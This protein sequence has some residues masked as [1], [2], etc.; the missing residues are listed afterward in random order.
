MQLNVK[1]NQ[2]IKLC[3]KAC[4]SFFLSFPGN[5]WWIRSWSSVI[6][7]SS[8]CLFLGLFVISWSLVRQ[9]EFYVFLGNLT[10]KFKFAHAWSGIKIRESGREHTDLMA[11][12]MSTDDLPKASEWNI[13]NVLF[14]CIQSVYLIHTK[15]EKVLIN[16]TT[17]LVKWHYFVTFFN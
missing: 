7:H 4:L 8:T 16:S 2:R 6:S 3:T 15:V 17:K 9:L 12:C 1:Q 13:S 10:H 5:S 14:I 11:E